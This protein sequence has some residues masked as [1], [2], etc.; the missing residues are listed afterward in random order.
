MTFPFPFSPPGGKVTVSFTDSS[1]D[2]TD[3]TT[4]TF[5]TQ[6]LGTASSDRK[7]VVGTGTVTGGG[8]TVSSITIAGIAATRVEQQ[9]NGQGIAELWQASVPTGT[10]GDIVVVFSGGVSRAGIG[11]WAVYNATTSAFDTGKSTADPLT[12]T[13][14]VPSKGICIGFAITNDGTSMT[15]TN[16]TEEFDEAE[17]ST[18]RH[19]GASLTSENGSSGLTVTATSST[20]PNGQCLVLASWGPA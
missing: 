1:V 13:I 15:W 16:L 17:E 19:S 4:Y 11:V 20:A 5:S 6:A 9:A 2:G 14:N 3:L 8:A 12:D 10:T 18:I 7:I